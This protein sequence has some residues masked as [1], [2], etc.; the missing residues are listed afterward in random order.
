MRARARAHD[1]SIWTAI[2]DGA[3]YLGCIPRS[4]NSMT[5]M[6]PPQHGQ[7][8]KSFSAGSF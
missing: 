6:R 3:R 8:G 2:R 1:V 4:K 7:G 5:I